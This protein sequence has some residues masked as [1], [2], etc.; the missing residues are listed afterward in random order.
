VGVFARYNEW[1]NRAGDSADSE[2]QQTNI[3]IN[4]WP[5]PDVVLKADYQFQQGPT[6]SGTV[7][8]INLGIGYQF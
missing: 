1:D 2:Y 4:Y 8:G 3:G 7:E 5:I 6:D